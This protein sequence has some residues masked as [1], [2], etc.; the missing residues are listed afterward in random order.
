ML[1]CNVKSCSSNEFGCCCR[2]EINV[3]GEKANTSEETTCGSYFP[4]GANGTNSCEYTTPNYELDIN[5]SA[6]SC[7]YNSSSK[8][9]SRNVQIEYN[10]SKS[11]CKTFATE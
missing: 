1:S 6:R 2:P 4:R 8:C 5:C 9:T 11:L 10:G 3:T 7:K